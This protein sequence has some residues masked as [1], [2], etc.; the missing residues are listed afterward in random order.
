MTW[1]CKVHYH[2]ILYL[3]VFISHFLFLTQVYFTWNVY[4]PKSAIYRQQE[5]V[6][7]SEWPWY[8]A[9]PQWLLKPVVALVWVSVNQKDGVFT[10]WGFH[11]FLSFLPP[12]F[13]LLFL[14]VC[15]GDDGQAIVTALIQDATW[16]LSLED[17]FLC[18]AGHWKR[19]LWA[20]IGHLQ[21]GQ[22]PTLWHWSK[23]NY[24]PQ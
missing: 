9:A 13:S 15:K 12:F 6:D 4:R 18:D 5:A 16:P 3:K 17:Y 23:C 7:F 11:F 22:L 2:G 19:L 1:V 20:H 24:I 14:L 8:A 10:I 21:G